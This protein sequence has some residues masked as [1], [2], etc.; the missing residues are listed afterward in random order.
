LRSKKKTAEAIDTKRCT[1]I[2]YSSRSACI[3]LEVK[4]SKVKVTRLRKPHGHTV[5]SDH[6]RY[7]VT[8]RYL[9]PLPAWVCMS[10]RPPMFSI[11]LSR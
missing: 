1:C 8:L 9:R 4:K 2:P 5:A 3:D 6:G 7:C 11:V 10:I